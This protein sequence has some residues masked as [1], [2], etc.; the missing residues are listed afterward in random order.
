MIGGVGLRFD[1][2]NMGV[3]EIVVEDKNPFVEVKLQVF[4][5]GVGNQVR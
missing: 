2:G 1:V 4:V 5:G 3:S